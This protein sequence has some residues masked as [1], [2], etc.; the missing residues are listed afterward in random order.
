[1]ALP[2]GVG[3]GKISQYDFNG[4]AAPRP[5][6]AQRPRSASATGDSHTGPVTAVGLCA[7]P[8]GNSAG[9]ERS[10]TPPP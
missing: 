6:L 3:G 5:C 4:L 2:C 7:G 10:S 9:H 8:F 1:M